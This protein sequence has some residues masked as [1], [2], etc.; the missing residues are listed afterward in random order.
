[1]LFLKLYN[2]I[3]HLSIL[4]KKY[5]KFKNWTFVSLDILASVAP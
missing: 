3:L 5:L 4:H 2:G 1:M